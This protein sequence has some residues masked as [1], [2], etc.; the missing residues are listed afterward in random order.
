[1]KNT[2]T[3]PAEFLRFYPNASEYTSA[4]ISESLWNSYSMVNSY[5]NSSLRIPVY[6]SDG[7]IPAVLK[8]LQGKFAVYTLEFGNHGWREENENLFRS[9]AETCAKMTQNELLISEVQKTTWDIGWVLTEMSC[10]GEGSLFVQGDPPS[11]EEDFTFM[12][13]DASATY[14]PS[15]QIIRSDDSGVYDTK[16]AARTW[17]YVKDSNLNF[18]VTGKFYVSESFTIKGTPDTSEIASQKPNLQSADI[19]WNADK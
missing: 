5:L 1:M 4:Q 13:T 16:T 17:T 15:F 3:Q 14:T 10:S 7:E 19:I 6:E 9:T 8:V 18:R 12:V 11:Y 2:Y